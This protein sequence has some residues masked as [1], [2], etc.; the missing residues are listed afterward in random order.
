MSY[1]LFVAYDLNAPGQDYQR[2]QAAIKEIG[3]WHQFQYSLFYVHTSLSP[4]EAFDHI[5]RSMDPNDKLAVINA[6][7]GHV[8]NYDAPLIQ[9]INAV[10]DK[11]MAAFLG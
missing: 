4:Q 2:V 10:W 7:S 1:N 5:K 3:T 8:S 6:Q 11:P 9:A